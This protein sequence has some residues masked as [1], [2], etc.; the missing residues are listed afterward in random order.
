MPPGPMSCWYR[1]LLL[2]HLRKDNKFGNINGKLLIHN[3]IQ[4]CIQIVKHCWPW[5]S[6]DKI[7][8]H[9]WLLFTVL[10]TIFMTSRHNNKKIYFYYFICN[11]STLIWPNHY[12]QRYRRFYC[13]CRCVLQRDLV[14]YFWNGALFRTQF[15]AALGLLG[16][17]QER[18][19]CHHGCDC[20]ID[21]NAGLQ[22]FI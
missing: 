18:W 12:R 14:G 21:R 17:P 9:H 10:V 7:C 5:Y 11:G 16:F 1:M 13:V 3:K 8:W 22:L 20:Q 2:R 4:K 15:A 6:I 19:C